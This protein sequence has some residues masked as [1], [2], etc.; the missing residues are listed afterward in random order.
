MPIHIPRAARLTL[1]VTLRRGRESIL[2][3]IPW[4]CWGAATLMQP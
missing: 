2:D 4:D 1:H 3:V